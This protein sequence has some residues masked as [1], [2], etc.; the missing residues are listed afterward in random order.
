M[1]RWLPWRGRLIRH[2]Y[3]YGS[4]GIDDGLIATPR[5][6]KGKAVFTQNYSPLWR[7]D[8][9]YN[10]PSSMDHEEK[11]EKLSRGFILVKRPLLAGLLGYPL[12]YPCQ[13][14]ENEGVR[15]DEQWWETESGGVTQS[16]QGLSKAN[17]ALMERLQGPMNPCFFGEH[18]DVEGLEHGS[19]LELGYGPLLS[20][21]SQ[22]SEEEQALFSTPSLEDRMPFL[23]MLQSVESPPFSP[24]TEPNF[25]ALLRLQH[26]KK[27]W[28]MTHLTELDSRIQARELESCITHDILEM[29]SPVKSETKEPQH[30]QHSTPCLEGTS[31]ECN[32]DQPNSAENGCLDTNSGSSPAWVQPQTRQKQAH[33][34]KSPPITRE[35]RKRKRTRPTKNKEEVESQ[36]MTHIAVERN[37]RRQM[38]DHLNALRSL[39]PTSYI[40]RGDQ[41][42]IIGGAIDFVKELEQLLE[43]LQAQKR[44]RRSEE[45]GDA[46]T[47]SSH[48]PQK[49]RPKGYAPNTDLLQTKAILP[50]EEG[51]TNS[52]SQ[53]TTTLEDLSLTVLHLNITSLQSTVLYSFNLKIE[54]DCK[55]GSADEVA[56]AVHQV[57]SF[58]NGSS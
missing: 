4:G 47:N 51:A 48:P 21:E 38:N 49:L 3:G 34:S 58:I 33:L 39:M 2:A 55:L 35:R 8:R 45:G 28:G 17:L 13:L 52:H 11:P 37:R 30:H 46:S 14:V 54:D 5:G 6:K 15:S 1:L 40:Q 50:R 41:A 42:S 29:H 44:M 18:L 20:T 12:H 10:K 43:S 22:R 57:F 19:S 53:R 36:R 24:F 31:S 26:Q 23:Q 16:I 7:Y 27:P 32:Q 9:Q 25:Q 56:A